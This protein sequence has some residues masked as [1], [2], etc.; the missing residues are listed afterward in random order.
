MKSQPTKNSMYFLNLF[1]CAVLTSLRFHFGIYQKVLILVAFFIPLNYMTTAEEKDDTPMVSV[2]VG[3][4]GWLHYQNSRF[5]FSISVPPGMTALRPPENGSGQE[6]RSLDG[7]VKV[8][9]YGHF[10]LDGFGSVEE[11]RK[12]ELI[13]GERTITYKRKKAN[14]Y[15]V[16]GVYDNGTG[17]Y[18]RYDAN[19]NHYAGRLITY[20]Q[21]E[22]KK[23]SPWI[24]RMAK[25][26]KPN[27]GKGLDSID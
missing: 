25:S 23:Y 18:Q 5:G 20:P 10:N 15:V 7:K 13:E 12:R 22:E 27:F 1:S 14:W 3:D 26:F 16:S 11:S 4:D 17:F 8:L 6:F 24:E 21:A 2:E 9:V 19:E